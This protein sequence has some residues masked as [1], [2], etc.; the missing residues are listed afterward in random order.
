MGSVRAQDHIVPGSSSRCERASSRLSR[1][2]STLNWKL[3][4]PGEQRL[5]GP[6]SLPQADPTTP[7]RALCRVIAAHSWWGRWRVLQDLPLTLYFVVC[8]PRCL[9]KKN[10]KRKN[11]TTHNAPSMKIHSSCRKQKHGDVLFR[12]QLLCCYSMNHVAVK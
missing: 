8:R 9:R 3:P 11:L 7:C 10:K 2:P 5:R 4:L 6:D 1:F 12:C